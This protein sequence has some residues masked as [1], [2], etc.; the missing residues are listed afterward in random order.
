MNDMN[1][2]LRV[3][4]AADPRIS[5]FEYALV[6]DSNRIHKLINS[7]DRLKQ[8]G[9]PKSTSVVYA[10]NSLMI[11]GTVLE[12]DDYSEQCLRFKITYKVRVDAV[13]WCDFDLK[14]GDVVLLKDIYPGYAGDCSTDVDDPMEYDLEVGKTDIFIADKGRYSRLLSMNRIDTYFQDK[15]CPNAFALTPHAQ[16]KR[17]QIAEK[18]PIVRRFVP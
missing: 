14:Q 5:Y 10:K 8:A 16:E 11:K 4:S 15:Y 2:K 3:V 7:A 12:I 17:I 13:Y 18:A 1:H 6:A 9:V